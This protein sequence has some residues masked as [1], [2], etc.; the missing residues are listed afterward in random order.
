MQTHT[1][2]AELTIRTVADV[3]HGLAGLPDDAGFAFEASGVETI[4]TPGLQLLAAYWQQARAGGHACEFL[5]PSEA[6][7]NALRGA[8]LEYLLT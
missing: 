4:T 6:L 3:M 7:T 5:H 8:G 1:L 2:P